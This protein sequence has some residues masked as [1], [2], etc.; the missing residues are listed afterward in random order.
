MLGRD[1]QPKL[2]GVTAIL[3]ANNQFLTII[4]ELVHPFTC[5]IQNQINFF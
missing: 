5:K 3:P 2:V 4:I 1:T